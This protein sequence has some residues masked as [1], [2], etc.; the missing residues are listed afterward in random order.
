M[1]ILAKSFYMI[2]HGQ[3][4]A[5]RDQFASGNIDVP[6]TELGKNQAEAAR[7]VV[8]ALEIKPTVIIHSHLARARDTARII[9][10]NLGLE[11]HET[12]LI[13]EHHFGEWEK[14][15]WKEIRPRFLAGENP[16]GG[17]T[18]EAFAQRIRQGIHFAFE[19]GE[20]PLIAC[21]GGV[22]KGFGHLFEE[23]IH[24]IQNCQLYRFTPI[25]EQTN[26]PWDI[27]TI[28]EA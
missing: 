6:L 3:S 7:L 19:Q 25:K 22:F 14:Q 17:E 10:M 18:H 15:P 9:N 24:G 27:Q 8:E 16:P 5:N 11:M 20:L 4:V 21:H 13:G 28:D 1:P 23:E 2:R 26:F 12:P